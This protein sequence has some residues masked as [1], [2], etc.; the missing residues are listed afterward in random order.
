MSHIESVKRLSVEEY[1]AFEE[2][3]ESR[4]EYLGGAVL[5]LP[6][7]SVRHGD[8]KNAIVFALHAHLRGTPCRVYST[9]MK[10]RVADA[11]YYPDVLVS[12]GPPDFSA[13]YLTAP[14]LVAE[15]AAEASESRDMLEK[16]VAYLTLPSL[17]EYLVASEREARVTVFRRTPEGWEQE[18]C[19]A[20]DQVRMTVVGLTIPVERLYG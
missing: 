9:A 17:R 1:L 14:V 2:R 3:E 16:R 6:G 20:G 11:F 12:C 13:A 10:L 4:H 18:I 7:A 8:V 19:A 15:V 5:E